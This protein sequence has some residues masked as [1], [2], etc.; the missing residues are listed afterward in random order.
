MSRSI[1]NLPKKDPNLDLA[2]MTVTKP[3]SRYDFSKFPNLEKKSDVQRV[4][5]FTK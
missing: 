1:N 2:F 4:N 3:D 5:W